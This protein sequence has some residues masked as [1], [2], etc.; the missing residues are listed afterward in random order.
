MTNSEIITSTKQWLQDIVIGLDLC[1]FA[2][3]AAGSIE[4]SLSEA[5]DEQHLLADLEQACLL[6]QND[7]RVET[8]LLIHPNVLQDFDVYNQF[9]THADSLLDAMQLEGVIQ[10][11]SFHPEYQF[12]ETDFESA[13]NYTNRSP[14][15]ML[16][17]LREASVELA[18]DSYPGVDDIPQRN[19]ATMQQLGSKK[20]KSK[21]LALQSVSK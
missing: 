15:P 4:F 12:A 11:A 10:V 1:P 3:H 14:Y 5:T 6:L 19:I 9:L 20:L 17:L 2:K 16:H 18:I 8:L 21:L 13:E 7:S